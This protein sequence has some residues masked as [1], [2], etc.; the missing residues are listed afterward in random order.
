MTLAASCAVPSRS[1]KTQLS[2]SSVLRAEKFAVSDAVIF[3]M[4]LK[5]LCLCFNFLSLF[6]WFKGVAGPAVLSCW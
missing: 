6:F 2:F 3:W 5:E 1:P 4:A